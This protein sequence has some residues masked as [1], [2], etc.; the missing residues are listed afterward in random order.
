M[1][2]PGVVNFTGYKNKKKSEIKT[3]SKTPI[4][5][6]KSKS[7]DLH[8]AHGLFIIFN[9]THDGLVFGFVFVCCTRTYYENR[10]QM[11]LRTRSGYMPRPNK[12]RRSAWV[13]VALKSFLG[14][15]VCFLDAR[16]K[17]EHGRRTID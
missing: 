4:R 12:M 17:T 6:L 8:G 1:C 14:V 2:P 11:C 10:K 16:T 9:N 5:R 15:L 13:V 7:D 3:V